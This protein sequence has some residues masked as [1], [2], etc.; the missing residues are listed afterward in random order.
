MLL[1]VATAMHGH[2]IRRRVLV[3]YSALIMM[4]R[5]MRLLHRSLTKVAASLP[6]TEG[7]P[8]VDRGWVS[9]PFRVA[10]QKIERLSSYRLCG[11]AQLGR[12]R[13]DEALN[14]DANIIALFD[15]ETTP[16]NV[17]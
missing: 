16:K 15:G 11:F 12:K 9:P 6:M 8:L 13:I 7:L 10:L 4:V 5:R 14:S 2:H 17:M 3:R 1:I